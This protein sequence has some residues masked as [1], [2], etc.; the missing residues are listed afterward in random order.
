M[1]SLRL[2]VLAAWAGLCGIAQAAPWSTTPLP[3]SE[4]PWYTAPDEFECEAPGTVLRMRKAPGNITSV[5][6]NTAAVW[7]IL[8]RTTDSHYKPTWAVTTLYVPKKPNPKALLSYQVAYDSVVLDDSPSYKVYGGKLAD[9]AIWSPVLGSGWFLNV[10]DYEGPNASFTAGVLSGHATIDSVRAVL[11]VKKKLGIDKDV[12]YALWGYSGGGLASE[13]AAE[14]QVQY[15]PE[16]SFAGAALGGLTPNISSVLLSINGSAAAGLAPSSILGATTQYPKVRDLIVS[17]LKTTGPYNATTFLSALTT[18]VS[19]SARIFAFQPIDQY[20]VNG[21]ADLF[22]PAVLKVVHSDGVMGYHGVPEMPLYVY[23]A[24]KD[25]VSVVA[26]TDALVTRFCGVGVDVN[27]QRN[28]IGGH[29]DEGTNGAYG[30]FDFLSS[31][32]AGTYNTTGCTVA[33]VAVNITDT[34]L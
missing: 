10:P 29:S 33:N 11:S 3:P 31:V 8:Y 17:K 6:N 15:A 24:V 5:V 22:T 13:W 20:F 21:L 4:D 18:P 26:D 12:K 14:L 9:L 1:P 28:S 30:A 27:Y 19:Q 7:N 23:K 34:G 32:L 25:E 2:L 16:L